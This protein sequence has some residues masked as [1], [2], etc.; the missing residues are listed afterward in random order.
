VRDLAINGVSVGEF[1]QMALCAGE[2]GVPVILACGCEAFCREAQELAPGI[3]VAA[4]KQGTQTEPGHHLPTQAYEKHNVGAIHLS[5][6][7]ARRRIRAAAKRAVERLRTEKFPLVTLKPP[8]EQVTVFRSDAMNPPR[9]ARKRH[10]RS[11]TA[12]LNGPW[13]LEPLT[14]YDPM[15]LI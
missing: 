15:R 3:E 14:G 6:E 9:V 7:E 5:P 12:M 4:I 13:N 10:D 11:V 8:Y 1:G 2:L